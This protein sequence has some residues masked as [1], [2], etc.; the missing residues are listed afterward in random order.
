MVAANYV[1]WLPLSYL[2][3]PPAELPIY[4]SKNQFADEL[5]PEVSGFFHKR[6]IVENLRR[7]RADWVWDANLPTARGIAV[8]F[9]GDAGLGM[10]HQLFDHE[11]SSLDD[12][13]RRVTIRIS[14][15][16]P[17]QTS[18]TMTIG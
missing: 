2:F 4:Y 14:C 6:V 10:M 13:T 3:E 16:M 8:S 7:D 15:R 5:P 12:A 18:H 11:V 17:S 1:K 9:Q